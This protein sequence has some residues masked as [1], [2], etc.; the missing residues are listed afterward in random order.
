ME[1]FSSEKKKKAF[2]T[3]ITGQDGS[4]LAEFLLNRGYE[5]HGLI[6]RVALE[7]QNKRL[8]RINHI[9]DKIIIHPGSVEDYPRVMEIVGEIKP[10]EFYHLSAQT[11]VKDSFDDPSSTFN[12]N[13]NGTLNVLRAIQRNSPQTKFYFAGTSEMFGKSTN[14][15]QIKIGN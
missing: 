13:I 3:G 14:N 7:D 8:E 10:D 12:I 4:Y 6:R 11:F 1:S 9:K 15:H 2:I 5:V